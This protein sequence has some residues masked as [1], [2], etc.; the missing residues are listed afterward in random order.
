MFVFQ[1]PRRDSLD[2]SRETLHVP[3]YKLIKVSNVVQC[4]T[5]LGRELVPI[6]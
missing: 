3:V 1:S 2:D 4:Y 5:N 6:L